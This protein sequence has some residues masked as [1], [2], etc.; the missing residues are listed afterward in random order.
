MIRTE[1]TVRNFNYD[2][3]WGTEITPS[4]RNIAPTVKNASSPQ[5]LY[6]ILTKSTRLETG[7]SEYCIKSVTLISDFNKIRRDP[8]IGLNRLRQESALALQKTIL[9]ELRLSRDVLHIIEDL[10]GEFQKTRKDVDNVHIR[11]SK[12]RANQ[13]INARI[14]KVIFENAYMQ[15]N[16]Y[17]YNSVVGEIRYFIYLSVKL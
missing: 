17:V 1:S 3:F 2:S 4:L 8:F 10:R 9:Q 11:T 14:V 5:H 6:D 16:V 15:L 7:H 12:S 13:N